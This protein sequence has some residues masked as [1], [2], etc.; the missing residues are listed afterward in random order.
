MV[1]NRRRMKERERKYTTSTVRIYTS[2]GHEEY[3]HVPQMY[4]LETM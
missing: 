3:I 4:Q 1:T 2:N